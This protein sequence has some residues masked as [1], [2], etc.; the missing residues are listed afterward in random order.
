MNVDCPYFAVVIFERHGCR[1]RPPDWMASQ[2]ADFI[3]IEN[4]NDGGVTDSLVANRSFWCS[5]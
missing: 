4:Q 1:L 5:S 2:K 3:F